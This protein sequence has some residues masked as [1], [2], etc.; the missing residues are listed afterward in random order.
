MSRIV[1]VS[2]RLPS[3]EGGPPKGGVAGALGTVLEDRGGLWL[4]WSG[5]AAEDDGEQLQVT[6]LGRFKV[7]ALDLP[8]ADVAGFYDGFAN[9]TLW[10]IAHGRLDLAVFDVETYA[11]YRRVNRRF[12]EWLMRVCEPDDVIWVHDY[13]LMPLGLELRRLGFSGPI[14]YFLHVPFAPREM[15]GALPWAEELGRALA[16][17]DLVGVQT[18]RDWWNLCDFMIHELDAGVLEDGDIRVDGLDLCTGMYPIG[19][20][21]ERFASLAAR[22]AARAR[23]DGDGR[24]LILGV[25]RL[26]YSKGVPHRLRAFNRLLERAPGLRGSVRLVQISA[27][28]RENVPEY[29]PL[30]REVEQLVGRINGRFGDLDRQPVCFLNRS[31]RQDTLAR[32]YRAAEVGLITPLADGMNLVAKE[33]VASQEPADPG[34]LVLSRLAGA[35]DCLP[36]ALLVNPHDTDALADALHAALAMGTMERRARFD[37]MMTELRR[38]DVHDWGRRFLADL[39]AAH[40]RCAPRRHRRVVGGA[41]AGIGAAPRLVERLGRH[42]PASSQRGSDTKQGARP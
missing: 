35:A 38:H 42:G 6:E 22:A 27:P 23:P 24:R 28:S 7:L 26:D 30:R 11:A 10:P 33:Y 25:D 21:V 41:E 32:L 17:Y 39:E 8:Q 19:I 15:A 5:R 34:V 40:R 20:D 16:A 13:H 37:S 3:L 18:S 12:A 9:R 2:N 14:G 4:G 36:G 31:F 1:A 29:A